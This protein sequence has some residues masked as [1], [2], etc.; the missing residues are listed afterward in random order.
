MNKCLISAALS[1][2]LIIPCLAGCALKGGVS[3]VDPERQ[4][5]DIK[6]FVK[7]ATRIALHEFKPN[8]GDLEVIS[9]YVEVARDLLSEPDCPDIGGLR[10]L[11]EQ[12]LPEEHKIIGFTILDVIERYVI[13]IVDP[14][15]EQELASKLIA[16]GL[17]GALEA[18]EEY[19][20]R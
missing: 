7:V 5:Q 13:S 11:A 16:A 6:F 1:V 8:R 2:L 4:R 15:E 17:T 9:A 19:Q 18:V 14:T 3:Q 20:S 10:D 12:Y